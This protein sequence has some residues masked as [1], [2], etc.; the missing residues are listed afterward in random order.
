MIDI[1]GGETQAMLTRPVSTTAPATDKQD[2]ILQDTLLLVA[3]AVR[4][5]A[6]ATVPGGSIVDPQLV[7]DE[8]RGVNVSA[9]IRKFQPAPEAPQQAFR[10]KTSGVDTPDVDV[11]VEVGDL[12]H[13]DHGPNLAEALARLALRV[14]KFHNLNAP[15]LTAFAVPT[16]TAQALPRDLLMEFGAAVR[17]AAKR[18]DFDIGEDV[19]IAAIADRYASQV[20]PQLVNQQLLTALEGVTLTQEQIDMGTTSSDEQHAVARAAIASVKGGV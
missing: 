11:G 15:T 3:E 9:I 14:S 5:A 16:V 12:L 2:A 6:I 20:K 19:D 18:A 1:G 10:V 7:A 8:I 4:D 13:H 17:D